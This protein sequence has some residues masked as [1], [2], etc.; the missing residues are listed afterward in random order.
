MVDQET[1]EP[2]FFVDKS[3]PAVYIPDPDGVPKSTELAPE[4]LFDF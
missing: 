3:N 4:E 2:D 1:V